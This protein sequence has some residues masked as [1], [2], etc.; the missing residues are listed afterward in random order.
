MMTE[1]RHV[2]VAPTETR[3]LS[4]GDEV[5]PHRHDDHQ[6]VYASSG[7]L[8]VMVPEGTWF[9]PSVRAVWVP[10]GAIHHWQ[11]HGPATV[12]LVGIPAGEMPSAGRAPMLVLVHSL[13]RELMIAASRNGPADT[14]PA[15][16]LRRVLVDQIRPAPG[17]PTMLPSLRD[18]RLRDVQALLEAD[19]TCSPG[20]AR[21]GLSVGAGERTLSRLFREEVGMTFTVWRNQLRLHL[22][23]LM[24]AEG[25]NVTETAAACGYSSAS[26]FVTAFRAAFGCTPGSLY[27]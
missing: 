18:P 11:V 15:R 10:A 23:T 5:T 1:I 4:P 17:V 21:L 13:L 6:L 14:P 26:A 22:A 16:R 24:L 3:Y 8:E 7:V 2:S 19:M 27:R 25:R 12:H 20:L 9:T